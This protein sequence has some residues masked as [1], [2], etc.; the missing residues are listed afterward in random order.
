MPRA[1]A[2]RRTNDAVDGDDAVADR[3]RRAAAALAILL[4]AMVVAPLLVTA[5]GVIDAGWVPSG[6][7]A[8]IVTRVD[9]IASSDAPLVGAYSTRGFSHPG[10]ILYYAL[11]V[12]HWLSSGNP[13]ALLAA[14][15]LINAATVAAIGWVA[16]RR[17]GLGLVTVTVVGLALLEHGLRPDT[18]VW[19][20]NPFAP[21][22]PY[23]L[24]LLAAWS[25]AV[26]DWRLLPVAVA[27]GS[28]VAQLHVTYVPLTGAAAVVVG[29]WLATHRR[30]A[31]DTDRAPRHALVLAGAVGLVLW[32]PVLV[33]LVA[34]RHNLL[35][36][37]AYFALGR[38]E[39]IGTDGLG[40]LGR[41]LGPTG[42]WAGGAEQVLFGSVLPGSTMP[43]TGAVVALGVLTVAAARRR[44]V[45]TPLLLLVEAQLAVAALA[46]TRIEV[47]VFAYL[48]VWM[49]PL[50]MVVW[51]SGV[52][53]TGSVLVLP[54]LRRRWPSDHRRLGIAAAVAAAVVL[55]GLP[56]VRT[57]ASWVDPSLPRQQDAAAVTSVVGQLSAELPQ[58]ARLRVEPVGDPLAE[59]GQGVI[60]GLIASGYT[61]YTSDGA[62]TDKWGATRTWR[63]QAVDTTLTVVVVPSNSEP[64]LVAGCRAMPGAEL[65]AYH[66]GLTEDERGELS[67]L[68][69]VRY[70]QAGALEPDAAARLDALIA[71]DLRIAVFEAPGVCAQA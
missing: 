41:H 10:P 53:A 56:L 64:T 38:G 32:L 21:L 30:R 63:E 13:S 15:A 58:G 44:H 33:D 19:F 29:V 65:V 67:F 11:A 57:G 9:D 31:P 55:A 8:V 62:R 49:L 5:S 12:P 25:V 17:G 4:V 52:W 16:W 59:S 46:S 14:T 26:R 7:E 54:A 23:V 43:L 1:L 71:R 35:R 50:A 60:G 69:T 22:L 34:G 20:W 48:V 24:F 61:V 66:D 68:F 45:A 6:D 18:L 42:P 47:P 2:P 40:I 3:R 39:S 28:V 37:V 27:M 36:I 51:V 70:L